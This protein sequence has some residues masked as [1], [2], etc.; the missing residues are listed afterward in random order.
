MMLGKVIV[1][2]FLI[3]GCCNCIPKQR[4]NKRP[5]PNRNEAGQNQD[6]GGGGEATGKGSG[7][8]VQQPPAGEVGLSEPPATKPKVRKPQF[9]VTGPLPN[10]PP[11]STKEQELFKLKMSSAVRTASVTSSISGRNRLP[12]SEKSILLHAHNEFRS[13][14]SNPVASNMVKV[15][16]SNEL[17]D[18]A[19]GW[20]DRCSFSH[21]NPDNISPFYWVGQNI[22]AGTGSGWPV[23]GMVESWWEEKD[24]Y[25]FATDECSGVCGHYTQLAWATT[26]H[27][28]CA[29]Q[30]CSPLQG[31]GWN[32][33][34]ILVCNYGEGGNYIGE[35][36]YIPGRACSRCPAG[37]TSCLQGRLCAE[38]GM[39]PDPLPPAAPVVTPAPPAAGNPGNGGGGAGTGGGGGDAGSPGSQ[40]AECGGALTEKSGEITSPNWPSPYTANRDCEWTIDC[41]VD[42]TITVTVTYM[43]IEP[44]NQCSYDY[45]L[46]TVRSAAGNSWRGTKY[47]GTRSLDPI[48]ADGSTRVMIRFH[49]DGNVHRGGFKAEYSVSGGEPEPEPCGGVITAQ[50]GTIKSPNYPENYGDNLDCIWT[51]EANTGKR[52]RLRFN[53]FDIEDDDVCQYD[54]I[55]LQ[56]GNE[57]IPMT[58][59][60]SEKPPG[61]YISL[62]NRAVLR[63]T[64]DGRTGRK[65]FTVGYRHI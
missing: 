50:R 5:R 37:Y 60:G 56:L 35:K 8:G 49:S 38:P 14:V 61:S 51:F 43:D 30:T 47:C 16:W 13:M 36:P 59:C 4:G 34:T 32:S 15:K 21:G 63:F 19:Q 33:A 23:Y 3:F 2:L 62:S 22:W 31:L 29:V 54:K 41:K 53:Q 39:A 48:V 6:G 58:L 40:P 26:T 55:T 27:V 11:I 9:F 17:A 1:V 12:E 45:I 57:Q 24:L 20:A 46:I 44:E 25:N 52:I 18:M 28:G 7:D 42:E 65:G 10:A 64:S